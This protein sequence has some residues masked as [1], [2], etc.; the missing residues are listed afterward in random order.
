MVI[1][2]KETYKNHRKK[3][4]TDAPGDHKF[5]EYHY[6]GQLV[7][8]TKISHGAAHDIGEDLIKKM[9]NQCKL[10]K[11]RLPGPCQVPAVGRRIS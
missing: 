6:N 9:A 1:D 11:I 2:S 3:G 7:L 4:F 10:R 8:A 5:L